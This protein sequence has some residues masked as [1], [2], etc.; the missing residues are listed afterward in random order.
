MNKSANKLLLIVLFAIIVII[1]LALVF[2]PS[3]KKEVR[4]AN[5]TYDADYII[6]GSG[7]GGSVLAGRLAMA[8]HKVLVIE[9]GPDSSSSSTDP[10]VQD[11]LPNIALPLGVPYLG[12]NYHRVPGSENCGGWEPVDTILDFTAP[13]ENGAY[14]G[15][16]RGQGAGGS[17]GHH[18]MQDGKGT[19]EVYD[20]IGQKVGDSRHCGKRALYYF[21]KMENHERA[22][23]NPKLYGSKGWLSVAKSRPDH[24]AQKVMK[25]VQDCGIAKYSSTPDLTGGVGETDTQVRYLGTTSPL[26][27]GR[28]NAF[29]DFLDLIRKSSDYAQK[30]DIKWNTSVDEI[31]FEDSKV[32]GDQLVAV[33]VKCYDGKGISEFQT[34]GSVFVPY[35][36]DGIDCAVLKPGNFALP[37]PKYYYARKEVILCAGTIQSPSVLMRSGIGPGGHLKDNNIQVKVDLPGVGSDII[38]HHEIA[39]VYEMDAT[40]WVPRWIADSYAATPGL[41]DSLPPGPFKDVLVQTSSQSQGSAFFTNTGEIQ[42]ELATDVKPQTRSLEIDVHNVMYG[43]F[44]NSLDNVISSA[45]QPYNANRWSAHNHFQKDLISNRDDPLNREA[46]LPGKQALVTGGFNPANPRVFLTWLTEN[47]LPGESVRS[48]D[49]GSIRLQGKDFRTIP[50]ITLNYYKDEDALDRMAFAVMKIREFMNRPEIRQ[51]AKNPNDFEFCPGP[52]I[53]TREDIKKF[54]KTWSSFGHHISGGCQMGKSSDRNAVL[55]S[56]YRVRGVH[57]LRVADCSVYPPPFLHGYN[58]ARGGYYAGET[59]AAMI[60]GQWGHENLDA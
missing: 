7:A 45:D 13:S 53:Q 16:I 40:K 30:V 8:G 4:K 54:I 51:Y 25:S 42:L 35:N 26:G 55:D 5:R 20:R 12:S 2:R 27:P 60:L 52:K 36:R 24:F 19:M 50:L 37:K 39:S 18:Y 32:A 10:S 58:T 44:V 46:G 23:Q 47:L 28:S 11:D 48:E 57:C 31:V 14:V 3:T 41:L 43:F 33:G 17:V 22:A 29:I 9:Q 1:V 49:R 15:Y 34:N 6:I 59:C 56:E 21:K 38:D